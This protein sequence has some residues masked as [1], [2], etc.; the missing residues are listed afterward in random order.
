MSELQNPGV[1]NHV[2][3]ILDGNRRWA[4]DQ[5]LSPFDGHQKG[6]NNLRDITRH[7]FSKHN[8]PF[9][10]AFVFST[11]N[12]QRT[13]EEVNYLMKLVSRAL[14]QYLSEFIKENIRIL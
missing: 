12:W 3:I 10:S 13:E 9:V 1:P 5:G 11:E 4:K 7:I 6:Y 14:N 2:G 8:V